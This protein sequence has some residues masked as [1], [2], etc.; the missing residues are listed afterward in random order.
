MAKDEIKKGDRVFVKSIK[1]EGEVT[2]VMEGG[3]LLTVKAKGAT[4]QASADDVEKLPSSG[5]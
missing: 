4:F 3:R 2:V 1:M 5:S